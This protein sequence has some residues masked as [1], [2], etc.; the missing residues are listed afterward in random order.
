M[1]KRKKILFAALVGSGAVLAGLYVVASENIVYYWEPAELYERM[2]ELGDRGLGDTVVRLGALVKTDS[3]TVSGLGVEQSID[4]LAT[5]GTRDIRV[6][7]SGVPPAMLRE[8]IGVVVEGRYI[9]VVCDEAEAEAEAELGEQALL[10]QTDRFTG[11]PAFFSDRLLVKHSNEYRLPDE[12]L[13]DPMA[14]YET[15]EEM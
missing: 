12:S 6:F 1:D 15:L 14:V 13:D 7:S 5:D 9:D 3:L 2:D 10:C 8:G 4:F 11:G